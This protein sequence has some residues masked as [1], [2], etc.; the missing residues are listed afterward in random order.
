MAVTLDD[1]G[2]WRAVLM[3]L[4][5]GRDLSVDEGRAAMTEILAGTATD[6][7][8]AAFIV[9]LRMKG[10]AVDEVAGMVE[11]MLEASD[12]ISIPA[13]AAPLVDIVGTGGGPTR[14]RNALNVSTM[15]CFVVA[16]AGVH[17]CKHGNRKA[18]S[19]SGSF[20]LLEALGVGIDLDGAGVTRCVVEAG[21]GF[22]FARAFHP[23]MRH[24][25]P[26][27]AELG[28]PTVFNFIGP[29][30]NPARIDRQVIGV[31][32]P[33][34]APTVIDVLQRRGAPRSMVVHG[35]DGMDELT[36]TGRSTVWEIRE[37]DVSQYDLDPRDLGIEVIDI[38]QV[39]GGDAAANA[40]IAGR[41]FAGGGGPHRDIV[42]LNAAA[43]LLVAG[44]V[45]D[46]AAGL[47]LARRSIDSGGASAALERM[48]AVSNA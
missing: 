7:Q 30:S 10:E 25:G 41:V 24:A 36:I 29:L 33:A 34:M 44:A 31:N 46:L 8:I 21:L 14:H 47:V 40:A 27:R 20:D 48:V 37:G 16:G 1:L 17:I 15:A 9:A 28:I 13:D 11:A 6:A 18:T 19:T 22:C 4:T 5:S 45:D 42:T 35:H 3:A 38:D 2:G 26:V 32:D 23:A 12:P 39:A 43:G